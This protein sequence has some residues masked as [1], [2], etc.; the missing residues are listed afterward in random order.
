MSLTLLTSGTTKE[1]KQITHSW[2]YID[3]TINQGIQCYQYTEMNVSLSYDWKVLNKT[4][5]AYVYQSGKSVSGYIQ[6]GSMLN[7]VKNTLG[8]DSYDISC[9]AYNLKYKGTTTK[10]YSTSPI[11]QISPSLDISPSTGGVA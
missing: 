8:T 5:K 1:P 9:T 6:S 2:N 7:I 3:P 4:T 11:L 10:T